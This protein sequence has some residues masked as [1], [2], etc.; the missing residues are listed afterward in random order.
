MSKNS[1]EIV[2]STAGL[3]LLVALIFT[4]V[5]FFTP[6]DAFWSYAIAG[7]LFTVPFALSEWHS[8]IFTRKAK[9]PSVPLSWQDWVGMFVG[10][11]ILSSLFVA[12]DL[13]VVH[14]GFSLIFTIAALALTFIALPTALR[15]WLLTQMKPRGG[16]D[17]A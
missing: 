14:P 12:I 2:A 10:G 8:G 11:V 15:A 3:A 4:A 13:A 5:Y 16:A 1:S 9:E 6:A 17:D 7:L